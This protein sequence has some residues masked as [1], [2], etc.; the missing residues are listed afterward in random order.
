MSAVAKLLAVDRTTLTA[1]LK[2]L[3]RRGLLTVAADAKDRR[4]RLLTLTPAGKAVL[5]DALPIWRSMHGD[6]ERNLPGGGDELRAG[7]EA[8]L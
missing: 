4:A 5:R 8:L 2:P 3:E 6:I 1:A 7:L